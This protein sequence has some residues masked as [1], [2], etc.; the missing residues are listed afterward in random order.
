VIGEIK[1]NDKLK[2]YRFQK[3]ELPTEHGYKTKTI[4]VGADTDKLERIKTILGMVFDGERFSG[5]KSDLGSRKEGEATIGTI[6][7]TLQG[8]INGITY[9]IALECDTTPLPGTKARMH[10]A[11][12]TLPEGEEDNVS[13]FIEDFFQRYE[14]GIRYLEE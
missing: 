13:H 1:M 2:P 3:G 11:Q 7:Y 10:R 9:S 5:F 14:E 12:I 8:T 6:E 4:Q